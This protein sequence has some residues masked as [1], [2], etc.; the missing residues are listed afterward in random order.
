MTEGEE[1]DA[2]DEGDRTESDSDVRDYVRLPHG[3]KRGTTSS[4]QGAPGASPPKDD[5][6]EEATSPQREKGP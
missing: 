2:K 4:S 6:E 1:D 5:E 3:T